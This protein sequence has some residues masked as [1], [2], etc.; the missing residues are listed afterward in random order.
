MAICLCPDV[1]S[2]RS[3]VQFVVLRH[4]SERERLSNTARWGALALEGTIVVE[5]G[6]PGPPTDDRI[7]STPGAVLLFPERLAFPERGASDDAGVPF[8]GTSTA[9][10]AAPVPALVIV[11]DGTWTQARRMVQRI[12]PLRT[13]PRLALPSPPPAVRLRRPP[14]GGMSTLEAMAAALALFGEPETAA[15]LYGL[16]AAGVER[17]LRL[18]G[19]WD[20]GC[21]G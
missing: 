4:A 5:H 13:M 17:I 16:H 7:L 6:L 18:K 3:P 8:V 14:G 10:A 15:R 11:P 19:T 12:A 9:S 2:L 20:P 21:E 1:P